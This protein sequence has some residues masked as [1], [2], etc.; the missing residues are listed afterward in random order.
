MSVSRRSSTLVAVLILVCTLSLGLARGRHKGIG[1]LPPPPK[2]NPPV[3]K[4][5]VQDPHQEI[6]SGLYSRTLFE[7]DTGTGYHLEVREFVV[8]PG[9]R[10]GE[11][12]LAGGAICEALYGSG[13]LTADSRREEFKI[14]S[15]F[16]IAQG[17]K[18]SIENASK[19]APIFLRA[20]LVYVK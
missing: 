16:S 2:T 15:N 11:V 17:E 8:R 3:S 10:T 12:N 6:A 13:V 9:E 19:D 18:F 20:H 1:L 5:G 4:N 7:T 14:G